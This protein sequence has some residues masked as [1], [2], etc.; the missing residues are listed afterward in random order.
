[1]WTNRVLS[2]KL[3]GIS[4]ILLHTSKESEYYLQNSV[5]LRTFHSVKKLENNYG[6]HVT[7]VSQACSLVNRNIKQST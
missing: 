6:S 7:V 4:Y 1:M 2:L 3:I 5:I